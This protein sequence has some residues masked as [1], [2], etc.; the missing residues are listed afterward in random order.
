[1]SALAEGPLTEDEALALP[2]FP[3]P[4][5]VLLPGSAMALHLF[6]PR[7]RAL[8]R[9]CLGEGP[10][11]MAIATILVDRGADELGR[12]AIAK[13]AGAGRIVAHHAR[14]EGTFDIL[15]LGVDRVVLDEIAD[16]G[17]PFR[18]ARATRIVEPEESVAIAREVDALVA[19]A[20]HTP[21]PA[22]LL[23]LPPPELAGPPA[24]RLDLLA[25]RYFPTAE[26]G[27][28]RAVL[29]SRT[30]E[31]RIRILREALALRVLSAARPT[32]ASN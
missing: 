24:R 20:G 10:M 30:L 11:A 14:P 3:L 23:P 16:P 31:A 13:I 26:G 1:V 17:D 19:L 18:R 5:A 28:R 25:D 29:E 8:A 6:E 12:P 21:M 27:T 4:N 7:Y 22:R 2:V 9:T 15:L 32:G